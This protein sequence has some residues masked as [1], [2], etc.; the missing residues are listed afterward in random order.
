MSPPGATTSALSFERLIGGIN[1][2]LKGDYNGE[3]H[4]ITLIVTI[5]DN[6][7]MLESMLLQ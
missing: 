5:L 7:H 2:K 4:M 1:S 6:A 3:W